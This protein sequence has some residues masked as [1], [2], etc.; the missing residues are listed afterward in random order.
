MLSASAAGVLTSEVL[1]L[2]VAGG[3][4][5]TSPIS[6]S[7]WLIKASSLPRSKA[8]PSARGITW[9]K[10]KS[11][12]TNSATDGRWV[13]ID[14]VVRLTISSFPCVEI[15]ENPFLDRHLVFQRISAK[16]V[17]LCRGVMM[18]QCRSSGRR[19]DG[20]GAEEGQPGTIFVLC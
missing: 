3:V 9:I 16:N 14:V 6:S 1:L 8:W 18:P 5:R 19:C 13:L 7:F 20:G 15:P 12:T 10:T 17:E 2:V 11:R 4:E